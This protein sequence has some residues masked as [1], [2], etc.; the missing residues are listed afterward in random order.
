[1]KTVDAIAEVRA[2]ELTVTQAARLAGVTRGYLFD[3]IWAATKADV[4][5]RD[6]HA[7]IRCGRRAVDAHHRK[8]RGS[9]GSH[10]P[11]V[12]FGL[13]NVVSL[14]RACHDL[15]EENPQESLADGLRVPQWADPAAIPVL[16]YRGWVRFDYSGG[17]TDVAA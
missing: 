7:C 12:V 15:A 3:L 1:M 11:R 8:A 4:F 16:T 17:W 9:G 6:H 2:F 5:A 14:C 10:D 13:A